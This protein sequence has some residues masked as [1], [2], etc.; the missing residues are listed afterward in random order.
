[1][2]GKSTLFE[3]STKAPLIVCGP[4]VSSSACGR[5]VEFLDIYPT[6]ADLV[7]LASPSGLQGASLRPLLAKPDAAWDRPAYT[8]LRHERIL[9][10]SV[11]TERYRYTEWDG[12]KEG[13]ELYDYQSDPNEFRNLAK[14]AGEASVVA[15]MKNLLK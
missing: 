13:S 3:Q 6:V 5:P 8:S 12:G 11:R 1:M 10:R 2:W 9:G 4:G 7:G 14:D 15:T